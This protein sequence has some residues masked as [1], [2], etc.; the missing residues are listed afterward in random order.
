[1]RRVRLKIQFSRVE[2]SDVRSKNVEISGA[3]DKSNCCIGSELLIF[4]L[5][6]SWSCGSDCEASGECKLSAEMLPIW[7]QPFPTS[8]TI[9]EACKFSNLA[10]K[11][12]LHTCSSPN[13]TDISFHNLKPT[14]LT[15]F[16]ER[17]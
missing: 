6:L 11:F 4:S 17:L 15:Y 7:M 1:M 16:S 13:A 8:E 5:N 12:A 2:S 3:S 10:L 9:L 14:S